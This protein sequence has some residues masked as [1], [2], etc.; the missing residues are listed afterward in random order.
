MLS[1][2]RLS[3]RFFPATKDEWTCMG[4]KKLHGVTQAFMVVVDISTIKQDIM[5]VASDRAI[6][7]D[8]IA[9]DMSSCKHI[10]GLFTL[11]LL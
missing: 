3:G 5:T 9:F 11:C 7:F 10:R 4:N 6:I 1:E 8:S 2:S